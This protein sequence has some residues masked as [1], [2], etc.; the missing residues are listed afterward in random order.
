[1]SMEQVFLFGAG[2]SAR[3]FAGICPKEVAVFGTTRSATKFDLL[4]DAGIFPLLFEGHLTPEIWRA[5]ATTTHLVISAAPDEMGDVFLNAARAVIAGKMPALRWIAYLST[6]GVY[7]DHDGAWVDE[8]TPC[9]PLSARSRWRLAAERQWLECGEALGCPVAVLRLA[10]I[11]G[12][13]RNNLVSLR[14]GTARHIVKP[15]QVFNRIHV[16]DIAGALLHLAERG[17]GGVLNV[18]DD[19]PAPLQ[20]V[21]TYAARLMGVEPPPPIAFEEAKMSAMARSFYEENK[22]VANLALK[23]AGYFLRFSNYRAGLD[24]LWAQANRET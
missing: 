23:E 12:P 16:A 4:R 9:Q 2:Y 1:M 8:Q 5:L 18:S 3:A 15:G 13:G 7:G 24:A 17:Q 21:V 10:G 22:R 20:D 11:Y 14:D 19:E 6:V